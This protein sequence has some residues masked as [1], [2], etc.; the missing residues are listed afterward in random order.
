MRTRMTTTKLTT[1]GIIGGSGNVNQEEWRHR[2][3]NWD[4]DMASLC[5]CFL[6][7]SHR[8]GRFGKVSSYY[9]SIDTPYS[10]RNGSCMLRSLLPY[11]YYL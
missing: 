2:G 9:I 5:T 10:M 7:L 3:M 1:I 4:L 6:G 8:F 11:Y